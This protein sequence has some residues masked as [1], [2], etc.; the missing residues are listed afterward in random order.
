MDPHQIVQLFG[1]W[2]ER[3]GPLWTTQSVDG[4]HTTWLQLPFFLP[5]D[6]LQRGL[7]RLIAAWE[8]YRRRMTAMM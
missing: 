4:T 7:E 3:K 6:R 1:P 5:P 8:R 2:A